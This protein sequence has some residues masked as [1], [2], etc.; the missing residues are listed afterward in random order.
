MFF[1]NNWYVGIHHMSSKDSVVLGMF[2]AA[3]QRLEEVRRQ[4]YADKLE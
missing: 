2:A 3:F 1:I 4:S